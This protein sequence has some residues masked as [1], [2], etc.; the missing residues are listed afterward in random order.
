M[1][2][3]VDLRYPVSPQGLPGQ[4]KAPG[5]GRTPG[6]AFQE[7]LQ[8][9]LQESQ[10]LHFSRHAVERI[11]SRGIVL[12]AEGLARI[13]GGIEKAASKG[14]RESLVLLDELAFIVSVKNRTVVTAL[15]GQSIKNNLFTNIDSA[16]I[17]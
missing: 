9:K 10:S 3:K 15:D 6:K 4:Q 13:E 16:I 11:K 5:T 7:L 8:E 17:V 12:S 2:Q 1:V 14:C